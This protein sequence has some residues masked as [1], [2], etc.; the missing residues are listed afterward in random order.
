LIFVKIAVDKIVDNFNPFDFLVF[1]LKNR[2]FN[3]GAGEHPAILYTGSLV[4]IITLKLLE[5]FH[6]Y[7]TILY[8]P[9]FQATAN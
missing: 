3:G 9:L 2:I 6:F 7:C 4:F 8:H 5:T 1:F